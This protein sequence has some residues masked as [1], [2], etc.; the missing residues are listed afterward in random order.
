MY[1][2]TLIK[3]LSEGMT[4]EKL[5]AFISAA[6]TLE[7]SENM[8]LLDALMEIKDQIEE[9]NVVTK[10]V[11]KGDSAAA[12]TD[13]KG[14]KK[15]KTEKVWDDTTDQKPA[16]NKGGSVSE[17]IDDDDEDEIEIEDEDLEEFEESKSLRDSVLSKIIDEKISVEEDVNAL[18][19]GEDLSEDFK[20][21]ATTIFEAAIASKISSY[22]EAINEAIEYVIE[23]EI[24]AISEELTSNI[25]KYLDY[26]VEEW[27]KQ[28]EIAVEHGLRNEITEGFIGGLK[29]LFIENY[30]E[31][32]EGSENILD[33]TIEEKLKLEEEF[34]AQIQKNIEFVSE[35]KSLKKAAIINEAVKGLIDTEA[36]KLRELAEEVRFDGADLF[37]SKVTQLKESY[38]KKSVKP[39][40]G[41]DN[42]ELLAEE[43]IT[44]TAM[45][46]YVDNL[47]RYLK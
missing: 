46:S 28:N 35:I 36:E 22:K 6:N 37:E 7:E 8:S 4:G 42:T 5:D 39:G 2:A 41:V 10:G 21:K 38:F 14:S 32:P 15:K 27:M 29:N 20:S 18:F 33:S 11:D 40:E 13:E 19:A 24:E 34:E 23:E 45:K 47:G 17:E 30:I 3:K 25:N 26:V 1:K 43:K 12:G 44:D 31:I 9:A 16:Q